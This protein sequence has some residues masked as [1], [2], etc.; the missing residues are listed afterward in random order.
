[1]SDQDAGSKKCP[2]QDFPATSASHVLVRISPG[3][4]FTFRQNTAAQAEQRGESEPRR[5]T[6]RHRVVLAP[7]EALSFHGNNPVF[8]FT[9]TLEKGVSFCIPAV[10]ETSLAWETLTAPPPRGNL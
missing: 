6:G 8:R 2:F 9:Q 10:N 5:E 1:M 3:N 7:G 4:T